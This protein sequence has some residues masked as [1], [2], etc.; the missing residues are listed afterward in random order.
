MKQG[1]RIVDHRRMS[2]ILLQAR[3]VILTTHSNPDGDALGSELALLQFLKSRG[4][5]CRIVNC[6]PVPE[7]LAFLNEGG[8]FETWEAD[9]HAN[10]LAEADVVAALDFNHPSRVG[11]MEEALIASSATRVVIDHHM[12]PHAFASEYLSV[13][14]ASSTAE[15]IHDLVVAADGA[16][17][18][19]IAL[20]LYVG[21]MTDTG[22]FRFDRTTPRVH[23][24]TASLL[25]QGVDP[26]RVHRLIYDDFPIGR[27]QLLGRV[28]SGI[29]PCCD[30]KATIFA[31]TRAML[32]ETSTTLNDVENMVNYGLGIRGVQLTALITEVEDGCK[33]SFRSRGSITVNDIAEQFGGGGHRF[34]SG[35]RV[36]GGEVA[37]LRKRIETVF[38]NALSDDSTP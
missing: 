4:V 12:H 36:R 31:V 1:I 2:E 27:T 6:D 15:I 5:D 13:I 14:E 38:S 16:L 33:I 10:L 3:T 37:E 26:T 22:S 35:A 34:A 8:V 30:G 29:E 11:D 18:Y 24:L 21:I 9:I 19:E 25:E 20:G 7:N 32:E 17:T 28:L 23:R